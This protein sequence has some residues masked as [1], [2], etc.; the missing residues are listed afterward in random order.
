MHANA[1]MHREANPE[2][3]ASNVAAMTTCLGDLPKGDASCREE[4][5]QTLA[6]NRKTPEGRSENHSAGCVDGGRNGGA[7]HPKPNP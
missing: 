4:R 2:Q 5:E 3:Y 6:A 7:S 1:A